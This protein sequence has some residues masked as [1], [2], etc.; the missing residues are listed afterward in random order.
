MKR[1]P[2][3][4]KLIW[5]SLLT[6]FA[7]GSWYLLDSGFCF[8]QMRYLSDRELI[9]AAIRYNKS[10]MKIDG[11]D[12][13]IREFL[14]RKPDCCNVDRQPPSRTFLD[15]CLGF[16]VSEVLLNYE[17]AS[18]NFPKEPYYEGYFSVSSCGTV[19][20]R[21]YGMAHPRLQKNN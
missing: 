1:Y 10:E 2:S 7:V 17:M 21:K 19:L 11:T 16:N 8:S 4:R 6:T 3:P 9:V 5:A 13:S 20:K 18:P 14:E 12:K 15:V